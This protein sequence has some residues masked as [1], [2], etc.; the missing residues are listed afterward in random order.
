MPDEDSKD[1]I[2]KINAEFDQFR[3]AIRGVSLTVCDYKRS[4]K[5]SRLF[6][7]EEQFMLTMEFQASVMTAICQ[8]GFS[9]EEE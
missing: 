1:S 9:A 3:A 5:E 6:T 7:R 2:A 8:L 4:L